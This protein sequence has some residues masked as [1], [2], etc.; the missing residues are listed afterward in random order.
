MS[1][2]FKKGIKAAYVL[3]KAIFTFLVNPLLFKEFWA[4]G[5]HKGPPCIIIKCFIC[6]SSI[7]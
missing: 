7:M 3:S 1:P 2:L 5:S 4:S 6:I